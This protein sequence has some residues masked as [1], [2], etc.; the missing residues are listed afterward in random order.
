VA[1]VEQQEPV[2]TDAQGRVEHQEEATSPGDPLT[3]Q[4]V[5]ARL[6]SRSSSV[7]SRYLWNNHSSARS[8]HDS[9]SNPQT[10]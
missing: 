6:R 5:I 7:V 8:S 1:E 10:R 3:C 9:Q 4:V 2:E